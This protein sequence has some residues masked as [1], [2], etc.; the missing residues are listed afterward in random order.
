MITATGYLTGHYFTFT[1]PGTL[2]GI[3]GCAVD[4][5]DPMCRTLLTVFWV[6]FFILETL[7]VT[8]TVW[9]SWTSYTAIGTKKSP[10]VSIIYRDGL[11]YYAVIMSLSIANLV[12]WTTAPQTLAYLA[13]SMMRS[14]HVTISSRL[15]LNIRG[16]LDRGYG[17]TSYFNSIQL[18]TMSYAPNAKNNTSNR[19]D[20]SSFTQ[21]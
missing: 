21:E 8:L 2:P 7:I 16:M 3:P 6:P 9:K 13:V 20:P 17:T 1:P 11:V 4:C 10:F 19:A 5:S 18:S 14:I 15:L 12:I